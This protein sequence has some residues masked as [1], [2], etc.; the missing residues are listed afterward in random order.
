METTAT[1]SIARN[2]KTIALNYFQE[3]FFM[4]NKI[5][6]KITDIYD[7]ISQAHKR[8]ISRYKELINL[9]FAPNINEYLN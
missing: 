1:N 5:N 8:D 9:H 4:S 3:S 2:N 6:S 7:S